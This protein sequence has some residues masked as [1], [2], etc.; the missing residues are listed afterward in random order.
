MKKI[1]FAVSVYFLAPFS[2]QAQLLSWSPS[3]IT[4]TSSTVTITCDASQGNQG[5]Y[6]YAS[7]SDVY[8]HIGLIT[9]A[10]T[11]SS[12]WLYV[13]SYSV[14]G[15]TNS[16][17]HATYLGS[18]KWQYTITGGLRTFFGVTNPSEKILRIAILFRN[19]SG[20]LKLA[21]IDGSDM[22]VPVY[23]SGSFNVRLDVTFR[24]P[25]YTPILAPLLK[26]V[27]DSVNVTANASQSSNISLYFNGT[28]ID[29][30]TNVLTAS[31]FA[32]ITAVGP[33]TIIANA[34]NGSTTVSDTSTFFVSSATTIAPLPNGVVDG[35]NYETGDTSV[36][37]VLYAPQ[38]SR[39]M[40]VGDFNNWTQ[41]A[42]YQMNMTPDSL[43]FWLRITGLTPGT[44]YAYQYIIDGSL[45]VADYNTEKILD[46]A[47]DP[48]IPQQLIQI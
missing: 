24:Q 1:L 47:N 33:Q 10:S 16:Q 8:V 43:R 38:K 34:T 22:F 25:K 44:E 5:L 20:S 39:I 12:N 19:G 14:W 42:N 29:T 37:L 35:I 30:V 40:V 45:T 18:N 15:S 23:S 9:S 46:K 13:P 31:A 11:S 3:F 32:H 26:F 17:I 6:N 4:D 36:V 2:S 41:A 48:Y 7:T 28:Q 21:N 27:G